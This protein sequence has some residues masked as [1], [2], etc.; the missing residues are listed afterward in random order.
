ML[1]YFEYLLLS[2]CWA[3]KVYHNI[4]RK[5]SSPQCCRKSFLGQR[6]WC[7]YPAQY[8]DW[9]RVCSEL[10]RVK[11]AV[12]NVSQFILFLDNLEAHVYE[13]LQK[14]IS[15]QKEIAWF[16]VPGA[17]DIWQQVDGGYGATLK[18]LINQQFF[19]GFDDDKNI[20]KWYGEKSHITASEKRI[21]ITL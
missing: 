18:A 20:E 11:P 19:D 3:A 2:L 15:N 13:K 8:L 5:R 7:L 10:D 1:L 4:Q 12:A 16:G 9:Y 21:L 14:S 6:C 17:T